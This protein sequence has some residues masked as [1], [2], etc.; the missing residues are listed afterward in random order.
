MKREVA[1]RALEYRAR[2]ASALSELQ[3]AV[4]YVDAAR[5]LAGQPSRSWRANAFGDTRH[6]QRP[7]L[8]ALRERIYGF[9]VER[10]TEAAA[11]AEVETDLYGDALAR[12]FAE[13]TTAIVLR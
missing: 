12:K 1:R 6:S 11:G 3:A 8:R 9:D 4:Y 5:M 10:V 13:T 7:A 2:V